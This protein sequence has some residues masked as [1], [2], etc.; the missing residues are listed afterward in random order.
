[1]FIRVNETQYGDSLLVNINNISNIFEDSNTIVTNGIHGNGNGIY[2][3]DDKDMRKLLK[4]IEVIN[5]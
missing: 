2:H 4:N 1:M 3:L 5:S